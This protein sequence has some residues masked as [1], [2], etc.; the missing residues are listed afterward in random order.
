[1]LTEGDK[2]LLA[3][4]TTIGLALKTKLSGD[5]IAL[6][7][8]EITLPKSDRA[9]NNLSA[10]GKLSAPADKDISGSLKL[11]SDAVDLDSVIGLLPEN[12][13]AVTEGD[14]VND[15]AGLPDAFAGLALDLQLQLAK[16]FWDHITIAKADISGKASGKVIDLPKV[17]FELNG[18]PVTG[19]LRI[20]KTSPKPAY[21][22]EV[23]LKDQLAQ[24][25]VAAI[26][27]ESK[28]SIAG[29]VT[30]LAKLDSSGE[31]QG[32][33]WANLKGTA[34]FK[35]TDGDLRVFSD[36]TKILLTPVAILL[37]LPEM[38]NSPI[39][40]VHAK[41]KIENESIQLETCEVKGS[42]FVASATGAIA[43]DET[44]E[45]SALDLPV[46]L[47]VR[48]DVADKAGLIP[49]GTPLSA[50]FVKLPDFVKVGG[51]IGEPKTKTNKLAIVGLLGQSRHL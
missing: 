26:D 44:L 18:M 10:T 4:P 49:K 6:N 2:P 14:F 19:S 21:A 20:D 45:A 48:R 25:L 41:L 39:D 30:V 50:K 42:V 9:A 29:K 16:A 46:Q 24:P 40:S 36:T 34:E 13:A 12:E 32:E 5:D 17:Q 37:R 22:F 8:T 35:F 28:E 11:S 1:M 23:Q 47:S 51:T 27:P 38:L 15:L 31:S 33:F 7:Q 3:K 43:L